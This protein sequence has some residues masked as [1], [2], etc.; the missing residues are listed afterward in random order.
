MKDEE[1]PPIKTDIIEMRCG[2]SGGDATLAT[3]TSSLVLPTSM[4][5]QQ[6]LLLTKAFHFSSL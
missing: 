3:K 4:A 2:V 1:C 5:S 6:L